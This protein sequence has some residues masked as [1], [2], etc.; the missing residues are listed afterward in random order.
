MSINYRAERALAP[1]GTTSWVVVDDVFDLHREA[2]T[3]LAGLRAREV[4]VNTERV[5]AGRV[6]LYLSYCASV[7]MDW[8]DPGFLGLKQFQDWL[9]STPLPSRGRRG[10]VDPRL[11]S[12]GTA[13]A[14]LTAV[15]EF[16]RF[17]NVHGWVAPQVVSMLSTPKV[18]R[19]LPPGYDSGEDGQW[20]AVAASTFRFKELDPGVET[21]TDAQ[22]T[23]MLELAGR[24]RDRFLIVLL[25]ST[26]MRIGEA[27]GLRR[28]DMHLLAT[29]TMLGC[30]V[31]GP[32][33][34]IRRRRDNANGALA[35]SRFPRT[36]P[37]TA[38]LVGYYTDYRRER[39]RVPQ[40]AE[41]DLVL[42]N[43]FAA[44]LG[45]PM[46]Y[47]GVK[48]MFDRLA[49]AAGFPARPHMFRHTAAT[50]LFRA[51]VPRDVTQD[52][53]GHVSA[54][55]LQRYVHVDDADKRAAV[56]RVAAAAGGS[57]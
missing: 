4:S 8:A 25:V 6:A 29:S 11:R 49:V 41:T 43:L 52:L 57:R 20:R 36:V 31:T 46:S 37:V 15:G 19:H 26:G 51:G 50:R 56:E 7:G 40:A 16:L 23:T 3:F 12:R 30:E 48:D 54:G 5:Y 47:P 44:P 53:L 21:F 22:I 17:G 13:N 55:S 1:S 27:L 38:D 34:H 24:A 14:V 45:R 10:G 9:I 33:I 28:E 39:D 42:V 18:L 2:T 35:K 32:H